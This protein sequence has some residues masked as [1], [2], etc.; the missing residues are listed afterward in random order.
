MSDRHIR[1]SVQ[2]P[3]IMQLE[4]LKSGSDVEVPAGTTIEELLTRFQVKKEHF[5]Y[6]SAIVNGEKS[7]LSHRL[8]NR[9]ELR[10]VLPVGGG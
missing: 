2:F 6:I 7:S 1:I 8:Q 4:K 3:A 9:E 10:L 5:Q